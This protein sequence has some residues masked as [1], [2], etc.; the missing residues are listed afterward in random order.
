V[1]G[2]PAILTGKNSDPDHIEFAMRNSITQSQRVCRSSVLNR[3]V[4]WGLN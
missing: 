3:N 1:S 2:S 4:L